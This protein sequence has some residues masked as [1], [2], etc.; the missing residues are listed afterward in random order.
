VCDDIFL[1]PPKIGCGTTT[2]KTKKQF[3]G[4][5][6]RRKSESFYH[7]ERVGVRGNHRV[8]HTFGKPVEIK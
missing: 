7:I 6:R 1:F 5:G 3:S 2:S 8:L 4:D